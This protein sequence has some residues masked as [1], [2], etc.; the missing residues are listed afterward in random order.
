MVRA[1]KVRTAASQKPAQL[2]RCGRASGHLL[3]AGRDVLA[4]RQGN[5]ARSG[6]PQAKGEAATGDNVRPRRHDSHKACLDE[7]RSQHQR[8]HSRTRG[9]PA[10]G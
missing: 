8:F 1:K 7:V 4:T 10:S 6:R 3:Q 2:L 9:R 5:Q